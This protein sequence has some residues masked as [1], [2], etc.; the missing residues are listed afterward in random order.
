VQTGASARSILGKL[1]AI[2]KPFGTR[3]TIKGDIGYV[4]H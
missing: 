4:T 3:V 2:S 1:A